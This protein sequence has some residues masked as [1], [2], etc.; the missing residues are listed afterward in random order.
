M[1]QCV[2]DH[3]LIIVGAPYKWVQQVTTFSVK[4]VLRRDISFMNFD[5]SQRMLFRTLP[6]IGRYVDLIVLAFGL[7]L[8]P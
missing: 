3:W 8:K 1:S 5:I 7:V 4:I 2:G 6:K